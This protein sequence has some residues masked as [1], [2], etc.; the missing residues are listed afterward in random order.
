[1]E[2]LLLALLLVGGLVS[3]GSAAQAVRIM[4]TGPY[5]VVFWVFF[6]LPAFVIPFVLNFYELARGRHSAYVGAAAGVGV[7]VAGLFLRYLIL[8]NGIPVAL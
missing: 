1:L 5:S 3:G 7:L 2:V 8:V 4:L 6:V